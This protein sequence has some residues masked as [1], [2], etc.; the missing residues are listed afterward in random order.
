ML[1]AE[2][3]G[4]TSR[5]AD[6]QDQRLQ[7]RGTVGHVA[8]AEALVRR[9][10]V[11]Q[12]GAHKSA[13]GNG[14]GRAAPATTPAAA[15]GGEG[16]VATGIVVVVGV[17]TNGDGVRL[18]RGDGLTGGLG[19]ELLLEHQLTTQ[20]AATLS[21]VGHQRQGLRSR[22]GIITAAVGRETG[23]R[24]Q[25]ASGCVL[26]GLGKRLAVLLHGAVH[27]C[28]APGFGLKQLLELCVPVVAVQRPV[29]HHQTAGQSAVAERA[30]Q[31]ECRRCLFERC[32]QPRSRIRQLRN[33][34]RWLPV[35][36]E[37]PHHHPG[38][39]LHRLLLE[40]GVRLQIRLGRCTGL[41][42]A[43]ARLP[44]EAM[45]HITQGERVAAIAAID[46]QLQ[47]HAQALLATAQLDGPE[48]RASAFDGR[49]AHTR[50]PAQLRLTANPVAQDR[51]GSGRPIAKAAHPVV[52]E[53]ARFTPRQLAQERS[54]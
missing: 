25:Q 30:L 37:L 49:E 34:F 36:V 7:A 21:P 54:P 19:Q 29:Q 16:P 20:Q 32:R 48:A 23:R 24:A 47:L 13:I 31:P 5:L 10:Q 38:G 52:I 35:G 33:R 14:E 43:L 50:P 17:I 26:Q 40:E 42:P 45:G 2:S 1:N 22:Q 9:Q 3:S 11:L 15:L 8:G 28:P 27:G 46:Q 12:L 4:C 53:A 41:T 6:V 44:T 51:L 39:R 18:G